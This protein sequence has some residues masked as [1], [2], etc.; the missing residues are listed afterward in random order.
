MLHNLPPGCHI[1]RFYINASSRLDRLACQALPQ[2]FSRAK[3]TVLHHR[4]SHPRLQSIE[5]RDGRG[6][7]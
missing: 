6:H 3:Q 4:Q 1:Q 5:E 2:H 7:R